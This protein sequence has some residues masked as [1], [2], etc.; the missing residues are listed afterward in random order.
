MTKTAIVSLCLLHSS[1]VSWDWSISVISRYLILA[2]CVWYTLMRTW[3]YLSGH[4]DFI[5]MISLF[6]FARAK[7]VKWT[8]N[9]ESTD[10]RSLAL[11]PFMNKSRSKELTIQAYVDRI[12]LCSINAR[13]SVHLISSSHFNGVL[14]NERAGGSP[15][16]LA[17]VISSWR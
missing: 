2:C 15:E 16:A 11:L 10:I 8:I 3:K 17:A 9:T 6:P 7:P 5:L 13:R 1:M 12:G 4:C 14:G